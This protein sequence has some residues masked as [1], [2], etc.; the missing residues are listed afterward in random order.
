MDLNILHSKQSK[1]YK[2]QAKRWKCWLYF[3]PIISTLNIYLL[4][5]IFDL[6]LHVV[7][8][9]SPHV[10]VAVLWSVYMDFYWDKYWEF[11]D[12]QRIK[13]TIDTPCRR[14]NERLLSSQQNHEKNLLGAFMVKNRAGRQEMPLQKYLARWRDLSQFNSIKIISTG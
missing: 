12:G 13:T 14:N 7:D 4:Y 1:D 5:R 6:N 8:V 10:L 3:S 2:R 11:F 9:S